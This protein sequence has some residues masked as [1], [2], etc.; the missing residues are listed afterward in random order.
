MPRIAVCLFILLLFS[1]MQLNAQQWEVGAQ[2]GA[3]GYQGDLNQRNIFQV[4]GIAAGLSLKY[5]FNGYLS[6]KA[7]Y[8]RAQIEGADSTSKYQ[9]QRDRNL[10]FFTPLN[11]ISLVGEFNFFEYLPGDGIHKFTPFIYGGIAAVNY[12]PQAIYRGDTYDLAPLMT[13]GQAK[14][15]KSTVLSIPIGA[16]IKYNFWRSMG[17]TFDI[18]YR[19]AMTDYLDDVSGYYAPRSAFGSQTAYDLSDRSVNKIGRPG[20]QRGDL[21]N[22]DTYMV[23]SIGFTYTILNSK[24]YYR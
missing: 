15:Y 20:T 8:I 13:E 17:V 2:L 12:K 6:L 1:A 16:G 7:S 11:E 9:Q 24:C 5:N 14:P 23:Y 3:S 19:T 18:G 22:Y 4:S 21:R 10:S